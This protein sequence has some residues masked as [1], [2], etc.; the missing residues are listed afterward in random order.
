MPAALQT[1]ARDQRRWSLTANSLKSQINWAR[2]CVLI[3]AVAGAILETLASQLHPTESYSPGKIIGYVG[4][5]GL[6]SIAVIRVQYLPQS[7]M[8]AWLVGR[9]IS[10]ALKRELY[11]YRTS[12][13]PYRAENRDQILIDRR[14]AIVEKARS[15]QAFAVEPSETGTLDLP[16]LDSD[17]YIQN[18][19]D[20]Q[21]K[22][23][24]ERAATCST[25]QSA[26]AA[27]QF[28]LALAGA[29]I[30]AI[31]VSMRDRSPAAWVAVTT[32]MLSALGSYLLAQRFEQLIVTY[33]VTAERLES[34]RVR[35]SSLDELVEQ[36]ESALAQENQ[37]WMT[38]VDETGAKPNQVPKKIVPDKRT[39][40]H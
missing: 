30:G 6:A 28:I 2:G 7:R 23:Y 3:L 12:T 1:V 37:S 33:R 18:R 15:L 29:G 32:T 22:W 11:R 31:A 14:D 24:R 38:S 21:V 17:G 10:E 26:F 40:P 27:V 25:R 13:G 36:C 4:A 5:V 8:Q 19:L 34:I 39:S 20:A 9:S 16:P 35:W